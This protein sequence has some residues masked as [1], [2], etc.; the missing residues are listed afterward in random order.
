MVKAYTDI[1]ACD[2]SIIV[3]RVRNQPPQHLFQIS[4]KEWIVAKLLDNDI[5][6][7]GV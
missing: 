4:V 7:L 3:G 2:N 6:F 1:S 5:A